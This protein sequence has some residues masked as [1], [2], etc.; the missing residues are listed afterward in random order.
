MS[1]G[2]QCVRTNT[3]SPL[4]RQTPPPP[5]FKDYTISSSCEE[6]L[7]HLLSPDGHHDSHYQRAL[8]PGRLC[9]QSHHFIPH[10]TNASDSISLRDFRLSHEL[11]GIREVFS[12]RRRRSGVFW[13]CQNGTQNLPMKGE[14]ELI[15]L[16]IP[17][18]VHRVNSV[19]D[20]LQ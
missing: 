17:C 13:E 6:S 19:M 18:R 7:V 10:I 16:D 14:R 9:T 12:W 15:S 2:T 1:T 4:E 8:P 11:Q 20:L 3:S 5:P